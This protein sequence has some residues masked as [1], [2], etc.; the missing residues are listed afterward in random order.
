[1]DWKDT[2]MSLEE[3][4]QFVLDW[5]VE[6]GIAELYCKADCLGGE[7]MVTLEH[8]AEISFKAGYNKALAQLANMTEECKQMGRKEVVD[9]MN[10]NC[11]G[12]RSNTTCNTDEYLGFH[13]GEG[14]AKLKE[15]GI[16]EEQ[17]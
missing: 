10:D 5:Y 11:L 9:W 15:W 4:N 2:V 7:Y 17:K 12:C 13:K 1:M 8:Q 6:R 14:Q 16:K 3:Y